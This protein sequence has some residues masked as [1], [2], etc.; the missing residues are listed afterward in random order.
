MTVTSLLKVSVVIPCHDAAP[1]LRVTVASVLNQTV[2]NVEV[3][4]V[5]DASSDG[6]GDIADSLAK[7]FETVR[8]FHRSFRHAGRTRRF[9]AAH[10]TG[11]AI[12]FLDADDVIA[13][14]NFAVQTVALANGAD[15]AAVPW[16]RLTRRGREWHSTPPSCR[17]RRPGE[18][19]LSAWLR[20]W[21]YPPASLMW[22]RAVYEAGEGWSETVR[23]NDDGELVM[24]TLARGAILS[25]LH[26]GC[27]WYRRLPPGE[28]SLS[29][30]GKTREGMDDRLSV[31]D[32]V[33]ADLKREGKLGRYRTALAESYH[34]IA[35]DARSSELPGVEALAAARAAACRPSYASA[36]LMGIQ[37]RAMAIGKTYR[38]LPLPKPGY[39]GMPGPEV[40]TLAA[41]E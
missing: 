7:E 27:S 15:I 35:T 31:V 13:P 3:I 11:D 24:R 2:R 25:E 37:R 17:Q 38:G 21:Y 29:S 20:G 33:A 12:V 4:I 8:V 9:G 18:D 10:A 23:I 5:D 28:A 26:D 14:E 40:E 41:N 32:S 1:Y 22:R 39:L 36:L 16:C 34:M 6:G 30:A 19:A